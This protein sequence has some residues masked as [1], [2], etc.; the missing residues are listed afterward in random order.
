MNTWP[1]YG[2]TCT[3]TNWAVPPPFQ[4]YRILWSH[5]RALTPT[6]TQTHPLAHTYIHACMFLCSLRALQ[7]HLLQPFIGFSP[8][9]KVEIITP[10]QWMMIKQVY[11]SHMMVSTDSQCSGNSYTHSMMVLW[12]ASFHRHINCL[13]VKVANLP[14]SPCF[15]MLVTASQS[16]IPTSEFIINLLGSVLNIV[17]SE[18]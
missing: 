5:T 13:P 16:I 4:S 18:C 15:L 12:I 6:R 10:S 8:K 14:P 11:T 7:M 9:S 1:H 3:L 2:Y 17:S